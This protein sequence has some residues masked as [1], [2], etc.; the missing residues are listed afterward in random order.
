VHAAGPARTS[1][2]G[3]ARLDDVQLINFN[4]VALPPAPNSFS[5][6]LP[7]K[8]T[9]LRI[10]LSHLRKQNARTPTSTSVDTSPADFGTD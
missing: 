9:A 10:K 5:D 3:A 1:H 2:R 6:S 7:G 8:P 4:Q